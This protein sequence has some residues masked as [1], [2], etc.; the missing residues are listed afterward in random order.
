MIGRSSSSVISPHAF[1]KASLSDSN[2][3]CLVEHT[4][5]SKIRRLSNPL[6]LNLVSLK[7]KY[8]FSISKKTALHKV[9]MLFLLN[10]KVPSPVEKSIL[11]LQS[12]DGPVARVP[13]SKFDLDTP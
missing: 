9:P 12:V 13:L 11:D 5:I 1:S 8:H 4:F 6:D 3:L 10:A 7:A 2:K